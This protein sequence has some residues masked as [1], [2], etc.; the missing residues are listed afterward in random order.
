MEKSC[1]L[2]GMLVSP[3][4]IITASTLNSRYRLRNQAQR[5]VGCFS[6]T[7]TY[8][9]TFHGPNQ[10]KRVQTPSDHSRCSRNAPQRCDYHCLTATNPMRSNGHEE[11]QQPGRKTGLRRDHDQQKQ[12]KNSFLASPRL[13][14][15]GIIFSNNHLLVVNK[16]PGWKSQPGEG[17]GN[18]GSH[19]PKC[20]LTSLKNQTLGGGSLQNFLIP[21]H[22]LDQPCSGVLM[23]AKNAKAA[24]RIQ[25]A[26]AKRQVEKCYWVVVEGGRGMSG[27]GGKMDG[28]ELLQRRSSKLSSGTHRLSGVIRSGNSKSRGRPINSG[29]ESV[30][31]KPLHPPARDGTNN[32]VDGGRVCH[33]E[34]KHLLRLPDTSF[35]TTRHLLSVTTDTGAKHQVRALLAIAGGAPIAGDLR[36][37]N[38][39]N[40]MNQDGGR[41]H[42]PLPDQSVALHARSVF[43]PTVSLG[44]MEFLKEEPFVADIPKSWN[45]LFGIRESDVT[46]F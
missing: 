10:L 44:G 40:R 24:S 20:L 18:S 28:L 3:S 23:F 14:P 12:R 17:T 46:H 32:L 36:Y 6:F 42:Q 4:T 19:D 45:D 25:V 37:G 38:N 33:I 13:Q 34:W 8:Q 29:G 41:V 21:T 43:L 39:A 15:P 9:N 11:M 35:S 22:R 5:K 1:T 30:M 7:N 26:W 31:V 2:S 27:R 16:T